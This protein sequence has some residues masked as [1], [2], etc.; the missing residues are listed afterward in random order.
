MRAG[1]IRLKRFALGSVW[2]HESPLDRQ[3]FKQSPKYPF[4][5]LNRQNTI[6]G[7]ED[8][9]TRIPLRFFRATRVG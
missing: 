5:L 8:A 4:G 1:F 6:T 3:G 9:I 7:V 2:T